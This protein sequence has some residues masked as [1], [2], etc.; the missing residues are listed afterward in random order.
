MKEIISQLQRRLLSFIYVLC[1]VSAIFLGTGISPAQAAINHPVIAFGSI[2]TDLA[3]ANDQ[4]GSKSDIASPSNNQQVEE[5]R[6]TAEQTAESSLDS[7]AIA[8]VQQTREAITDLENN[9]PK[10]ALE[11]LTAAT[12]KLDI[13]LAREPELG[14]IPIS[15]TVEVIDTAPLSKD[16]AEAL[17]DGVVVAVQKGDYALA[18]ELLANMI[19]E[20]RTQIVNVPLATY[21]EAMKVAAG[22]IDADKIDEAKEVLEVALSTLVI[23]ERTQPIPMIDAQTSLLGAIA[24]STEDKAEAL[25]LVGDAREDLQLAKAL[26]YVSED[27]TYRELDDEIDSI[28]KKLKRNVDLG[29]ALNKVENKLSGFLN[30]ISSKEPD[31]LI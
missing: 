5:K 9:N 28:E 25:R 6:Q 16:T 18:R 31:F 7:D 15:S 22:L 29:A 21:P 2:S 17:R 26:G 19:S 23:A 8:A 11:H 27:K 12:G 10:E 1:F 24:I 20:V 14:L 3:A 30:R 13:L 4:L